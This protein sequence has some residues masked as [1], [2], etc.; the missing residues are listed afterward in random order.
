MAIIMRTDVLQTIKDT[1]E[2]TQN[3]TVL[4]IYEENN[5]VFGIYVNDVRDSLSFLNVPP[6]HLET[7]VLGI[8]IEFFELGAVLHHIYL[9]GAFKFVEILTTSD[10]NIA[11]DDDL[12][13]LVDF[14]LEK[15]PFNVAQANFLDAFLKGSIHNTDENIGTVILLRDMMI[16]FLKYNEMYAEDKIEI[17]FEVFT[18]SIETDADYVKVYNQLNSF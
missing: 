7:I 9:T 1:L 4:S 18:D 5:V 17:D 6:V 10:K 2:Q 16:Q 14:L 11:P 3:I 12:M 13:T 8:H 15:L